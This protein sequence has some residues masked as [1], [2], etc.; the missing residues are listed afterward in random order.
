MPFK[1][2][3]VPVIAKV[4]EVIPPTETAAP[5]LIVKVFVDV[6]SASLAVIVPL[7][8]LTV[9]LS[10]K[11]GTVAKL[12]A[13]LPVP[14]EL[15]NVMPEKPLLKR[16]ISVSSSLSVPVASEPMAIVVLVVLGWI[17][18]AALPDSAP[19]KLISSVVMVNA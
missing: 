15:P 18:K 7:E 2:I 10:A 17:T 16:P 6:S 4:P 9:R 3:P 12:I 13:I 1:V 19:P 5:L 11:V 8:L 14:L